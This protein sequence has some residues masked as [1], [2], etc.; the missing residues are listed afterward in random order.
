MDRPPH[1]LAAPWKNAEV[2]PAFW[3][4][5]RVLVTGNTGFKGSWLTAWLTE[6]GAE[7]C[8][9]SLKPHTDP[10]LFD[11]LGLQQRFETKM[12]DIRDLDTLKGTTLRFEPEIVFHLAAQPLV[13]ESY[14]APVETYA[15][16]VMGTVNLL[17]AVSDTASVRSCVVVTS[18]KCYE[19]HEW[20]WAYRESDTIGGHDPYSGSKA[21]AE[22]VT[23]AWRRSFLP[24]ERYDQHRVGLA[25]ARAGNVIGGGDWSKPRLIPDLV[26]A[27][28][29][30]QPAELLSPQ[31][32]RPWQHVIEPLRGYLILAQAC[33]QDGRER[34]RSYNF[35]PSDQG[36]ATVG[37][38]A[39]RF[40]TAWGDR[41]AWIDA[42]NQA[43][44]Y[45]A[46]LLRLDSGLAR[47]ELGWSPRLDLTSAIQMTADWY[48]AWA[49]GAPRNELWQLLLSQIVRYGGGL[50]L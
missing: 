3:R 42:S 30:G 5:R 34:A 43:T 38:V 1:A 13:R 35:A 11:L 50:S 21:C 22:I 16:N 20:A 32:V 41:A 19:N 47:R 8:G 27:F 46:G 25:S 2:D 14:R 39:E 6:M 37:E 29:A 4:A 28:R 10:S 15:I 36:L 45:E 18:D 44:L 40:A 9:Y 12:A 33:Y 23:S 7:V 24:P 17:A 26:R 48:R 31:S 49:K